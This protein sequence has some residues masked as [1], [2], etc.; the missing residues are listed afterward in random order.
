MFQERSL[1]ADK[2]PEELPKVFLQV[3]QTLQ[4]LQL[5]LLS[6]VLPSSQGGALCIGDIQFEGRC[7]SISVSRKQEGDEQCRLL[8][9]RAGKRLLVL[10]LAE[11]SMP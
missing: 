11:P 4:L 5:T 1:A 6:P 7:R 8:G 9:L 3:S 2:E 10:M